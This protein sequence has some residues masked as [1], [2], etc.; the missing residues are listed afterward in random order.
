MS[1]FYVTADKTS[2]GTVSQDTAMGNLVRAR[3]TRLVSVMRGASK[4]PSKDF[5]RRKG[6]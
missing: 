2:R 1:F 5:S 4:K 3:L 6:P